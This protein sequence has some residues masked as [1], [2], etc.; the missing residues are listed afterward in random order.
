[1]LT[2]RALANRIRGEVPQKRTKGKGTLKKQPILV[3]QRMIS[4]QFSTFARALTVEG[5]TPRCFSTSICANRQF[6]P[7]L[8]IARW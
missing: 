3:F 4:A 7:I 1:M 8:T 5:D 6:K 2:W